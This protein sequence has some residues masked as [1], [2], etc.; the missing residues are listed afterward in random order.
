MQEE[1]VNTSKPVTITQQIGAFARPENL[2]VDRDDIADGKLYELDDSKGF[3]L[4]SDFENF[5]S[6][7]A[8]LGLHK[9]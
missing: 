1:G 9:A 5:K 7:P 4:S 2:I 3:V 6:G 8:T